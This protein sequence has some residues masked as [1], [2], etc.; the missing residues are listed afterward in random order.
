MRMAFEHRWL[1]TRQSLLCQQLQIC[2]GEWQPFGG[3][4]ALW[5]EIEPSRWW[6]CLQPLLQ[7]PVSRLEKS[8]PLAPR[9]VVRGLGV[10]ISCIGIHLDWQKW[11]HGPSCKEQSNCWGGALSVVTLNKWYDVTS[12]LGQHIVAQPDSVALNQVEVIQDQLAHMTL[13]ESGDV[14][15]L[16]CIPSKFG[17]AWKHQSDA[18]SLQPSIPTSSIF[19]CCTPMWCEHGE[20]Y[21]PF[22]FHRLE[23]GPCCGG[24]QTPPIAHC[25]QWWSVHNNST[26]LTWYCQP[27]IAEIVKQIGRHLWNPKFGEHWCLGHHS[28]ASNLRQHGCKRGLK[29]QVPP[30]TKIH[31]RHISNDAAPNNSQVGSKLL[32]WLEGK[33]RQGHTQ[34]VRSLLMDAVRIML[35]SSVAQYQC[36]INNGMWRYYTNMQAGHPTSAVCIPVEVHGIVSSLQLFLGSILTHIFS[37]T[38]WTFCLIFT[39]VDKDE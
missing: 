21:P 29:E 4:T 34:Q 35:L 36:N 16:F 38:T 24:C 17:S 3:H 27:W 39:T 32:R 10:A 11:W 2:L 15:R 28:S 19:G 6:M 33:L 31:S 18:C 13:E 20:A 22:W 23:V 1:H 5:G 26:P 7:L 37:S 9:L 25:L 30:Y 8:K 12:V 14:P